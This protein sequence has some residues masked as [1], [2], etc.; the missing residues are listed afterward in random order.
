MKP[1]LTLLM[2]AFALATVGPD[3]ADARRFGGGTSFGKHR[4]HKPDLPPAATRH[5]GPMRQ[6]A[7]AGQRGSATTGMMGGLLGGLLVGGLIGSLIAGGGF[8]GVNL[9]DILVLGGLLWLGFTLLRRKATP[10]R[11]PHVSAKRT[12]DRPGIDEAH[13]LNA[14]REIFLRM[15]RAWDAGDI[16]DI[17]RFSTPEVA[18]T[19]AGMMKEDEQ[20]DTEVLTLNAAIADAWFEDG[21]EYVAVAFD[22]ALRERT[23]DASGPETD[24]HEHQIR[25]I[26]TFTHDPASEDPTWYLA[27]IEQAH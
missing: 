9:L 20:H 1:L 3:D 2:L 24:Q 26:W 12:T 14:A 17:R 18:E 13:F 22:A 16:E 27:G 15:Q 8:Q 19:I 4:L 10:P 23:R 6:P 25:E 7:P 21:R 11:T 5:A